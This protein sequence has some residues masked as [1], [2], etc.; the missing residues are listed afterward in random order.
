MLAD[1]GGRHLE[2]GD[3]GEAHNLKVRKDDE[4]DAV[5]GQ[6]KDVLKS[7]IHDI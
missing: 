2:C 7:C 1:L 3:G 6:L 5:H 4:A